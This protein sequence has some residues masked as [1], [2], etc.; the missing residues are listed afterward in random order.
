VLGTGSDEQHDYKSMII[1]SN[2]IIT[3]SSP[4]LCRSARRNPLK[5]LVLLIMVLFY[6]SHD[7]C[8]N[9]DILRG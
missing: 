9:C 4:G 6:Y 5:E 1:I 8:L 3:F 7:D 2:Y